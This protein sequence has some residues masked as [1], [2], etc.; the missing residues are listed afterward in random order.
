MELKKLIFATSNQHK[1]DEV[2]AVLGMP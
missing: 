2:A 1:V